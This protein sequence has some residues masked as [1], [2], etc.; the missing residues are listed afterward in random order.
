FPGCFGCGPDH[1]DGLHCL[2]GEAGGGV[3]AVAWTARETDAPFVW[4][5]LDCS[6][7][8]PV[9]PARGGRPH[10]LGRI[11][12]EVREEV[13]PAEPHVVVSWALGAEGRRKHSASA[14]LGP[15]GDAVAVARATWFAL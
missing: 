5:A 8:G 7:C 9:V 3:W 1:P 6:S 13:R 4:S 15:R 12:A 11:A 14:I 10:V 2:P